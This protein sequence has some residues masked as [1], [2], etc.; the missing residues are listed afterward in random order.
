MDSRIQE[1]IEVERGCGYRKEG[2]MYLVNYGGAFN[3]GKLPIPLTVCPVCGEGIR[4]SR[5]PRMLE[6]PAAL[7]L[8][9][10]CKPEETKCFMCPLGRIFGPTLL[11]WV[12]KEYYPTPH[13]FN[14]EADSLGIS[15]RIAAIPRGFK[16][17]ETWVLLAHERAITRLEIGQEPSIT[18]GIFK[19]FK[20]ERIEVVCTGD[21][22]PQQIDDYIARGL[23]PVIM[24]RE[25]QLTIEQRIDRVLGG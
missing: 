24:K 3:C 2:G 11:I 16:L 7:W 12:G 10:P 15:R 25:Q 6:N 19:A 9:I 8:S 18:P 14:K 13:D 5:A 22:T 20:P 21:E 23:T 4:P 1:V 17:G